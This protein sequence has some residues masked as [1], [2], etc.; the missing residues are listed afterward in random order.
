VSQ[1][2]AC[3]DACVTAINEFDGGGDP[4]KLLDLLEECKTLFSPESANDAVI[5]PYADRAAEAIAQA[6]V[7][8]C[9]KYRN[10]VPFFLKNL[11]TL[12]FYDCQDTVRSGTEEPVPAETPL[13]PAMS[14]FD[15]CLPRFVELCVEK[16]LIT[17]G[18]ENG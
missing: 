7:R 2:L 14:P 3:L 9:E 8:M 18:E 11:D 4:A 6:A 1:E 10:S 12:A 5:R 17:K 13:V 15:A 16:G